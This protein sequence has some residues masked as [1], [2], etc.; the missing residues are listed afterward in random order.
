MSRDPIYTA[1]NCKLAY[2]LN[3]S[4]TIF[5]RSQALDGDWLESLSQATEPDGIRIL[6][7]RL[8][9]PDASQFLI[10]TK[11]E[12]PASLIPARVKGRLQ[13]LIRGREPKAFQRNYSLRSVGSTRREK[14]EQYVQSQLDRH[15]PADERVAARFLR[16]QIHDRAVDLSAPRYTTHALYWYNL[17][18]V[19][20]N[21]G[22]WREI[23][24]RVLEAMCSML[25]QASRSKGHLL[26]RGGIVLDHL[27]LTLGCGPEESPLNVALA[28][29][30]NLAYA[31]GMRPVFTFSCFVG[32]FGE[33]DLGATVVQNPA[34]HPDKPGGGG[35]GESGSAL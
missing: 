5:W 22:R 27:H 21:A 4:L 23:D 15:P 18:V 12:V 30:N 29:M 25:R 19:L 11:P 14:L 32:T 16:Y 31:A 28:Y 8:A 26:S 9:T 34:L 20:V 1:D 24:D 13:H 33:Y 35:R 7:H 17:H 2:Q 10:S 6:N 3:W